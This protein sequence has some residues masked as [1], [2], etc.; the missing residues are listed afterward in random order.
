ML[1]NI[2]GCKLFQCE[3]KVKENSEKVIV[4]CT[5]DKKGLRLYSTV[6]KMCIAKFDNRKCK[7][8]DRYLSRLVQY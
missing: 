8:L 7:M 2:T 1:R 6:A 5:V 3:V 4:P